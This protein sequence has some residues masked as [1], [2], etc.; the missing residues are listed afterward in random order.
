MPSNSNPVHTSEVLAT[1]AAL[2]GYFKQTESKIYRSK[3]DQPKVCLALSGGGIRASAFGL[4]VIQGLHE[5]GKL[6]DIDIISAVSGGAYTL[7]WYVQ[8]RAGGVNE[9]KV[10]SDVYIRKNIRPSLFSLPVAAAGSIF[11]LLNPLTAGSGFVNG[12]DS[13]GMKSAYYGMVAG[14]FNLPFFGELSRRNLRSAVESGSIPMPIV[15]IAAYPI[16]GP[17]YSLENP[18]MALTSLAKSVALYDT[19][20]EVTPYRYG[21][22]GIGFQEGPLPPLGDDLWEYVLYSGAAYD[23]PHE[24]G[25]VKSLSSLIHLGGNM[26]LVVAR[27]YP[28]PHQVLTESDVRRAFFY[29]TDGG[30]A[31][32]LAVFPLVMRRCETIIIADSE[33]DPE[34]VM[35]GYR[36]L[37]TRL[38]NEHG[39]NLEV[40]G[41]DALKLAPEA[42]ASEFTRADGLKLW[43]TERECARAPEETPC[44]SRDVATTVFDGS[45]SMIP[46]TNSDFEVQRKTRVIY[47]KL[48]LR[49]QSLQTDAPES[50]RALMTS[51]MEAPRSCYFPHDP[52]FN[53]QNPIKSQQYTME[54]FQAYKDLARSMAQQINW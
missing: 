27:T 35:E 36:V 45:I 53:R 22:S 4:G 33:H 41:I 26:S 16:P 13:T 50:V 7:A 48:G 25:S 34:W 2:S 14:S 29:A 17:V 49:K 43:Q 24:Q 42:Q 19:Y 47:L 28:T 32:N 11:S 54:Q 6:A 46:L 38:L 40:Q 8:E 12:I 30:F 51:C 18:K 44:A 5:T 21:V 37:K 39:L 15:G 10:L 52:T 23:R 31:E 1:N 9:E 20:L 3:K